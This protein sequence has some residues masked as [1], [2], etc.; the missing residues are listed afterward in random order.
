MW[1]TFFL[2]LYASPS[3]V[4]HRDKWSGLPIVSFP[5]KDSPAYLL[6]LKCSSTIFRKV[7]CFTH[8]RLG[9]TL[10]ANVPGRDERSLMLVVGMFTPSSAFNN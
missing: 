7:M 8:D 6:K 9:L 10:P 2:A 5:T 1:E 3:Q 4:I